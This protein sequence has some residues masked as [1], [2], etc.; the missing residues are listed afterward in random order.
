MPESTQL[1]TAKIRLRALV[2]GFVFGLAICLLTPYHVGYMDGTPLSGGHFPLAPFFIVIWMF[3][4]FAALAKLFKTKPL[5][6]GLELMVTWAL[7]LIV[8]GV[9]S[10]GLVRTFFHN[11]TAPIYFAKDGYQWT[12]G[13]TP[14]LP[15]SWR[16]LDIQAVE[17]LY[18]G[19]E[20]GREMSWSAVLER[21][22]WDVWLP[23]LL[24]WS[25]F[26]L[27]CYFVMICLVNM[28]GR[29]WIVNERVNFPLLQAP[30]LM[31]EAYDEG[32]LGA[33][34]TDKYLLSGL[35]ITAFLHSL[36][37]LHHYNPS[38]PMLPT[39]VLAGSYFPKYGLFSGF[40]KLKLY[41]FPAFIGFAFLANRQISFS[42]W[43]FYALGGL[44]FG[45]LYVLGMQYPED[46]LGMTFGPTFAR[47]EEAQTI[48]AYLVFFLFL[49]FLARQHIMA[50]IRCGL[51]F[52]RSET[53]Q[54][55]A[56]G[57]WLPAS[58]AAWGS[59]LGLLAI[60]AWCRAFNMSWGAAI[61]LP[62]VFFMI[63]IVVSRI[64]C[65][66]GLPYFTLT[67]APTD[68]LT[69]LFGAKFY[70]KAGL[71]AAVIMQKILFLDVRESLMPSL[72][73]GAKATER[74][75]NQKLFLGGMA[76]LLLLAVTISFVAMLTVSHKYGLRAIDDEWASRSTLLVYENAQRLLDVDSEPNT[77]IISF[78]AAGAVVMLGLVFMYYR[79]NWWPIH[80]IGYLAT[81]SEGMRILWFSFFMGW[82]CNHLCLHYGGTNLFRQVRFL[83]IGLIIGD[84]LMGGIFGVIGL[85]TESSYQVFP[86]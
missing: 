2:A 38:V 64:I 85:F 16:P 17:T 67:A 58:W 45:V 36:N 53:V 40:H 55:S 62:L 61:L 34:F 80:P 37:G 73:H 13:L 27:L 82:L 6:S 26:I 9:G 3:V 10:T 5:F 12:E 83:F 43:F 23:P 66:G 54:C 46:V 47:P 18:N 24:T 74:A 71:V 84:L 33:F 69:G 81:Y 72:F 44:L 14:L 77:W 49:V 30:R 19:L 7:M 22:P 70:G 48:G 1:N 11:L 86:Q 32:R 68:G 8:S 57:Q 60:M 21:I 78:S 41:I 31:S 63:L 52:G 75:R 51:G 4:I 20:G 56:P 29:Q 35:L 28:F 65:Q 79:F 76:V 42:F 25:A 59:F 50:S 15:E 39:L